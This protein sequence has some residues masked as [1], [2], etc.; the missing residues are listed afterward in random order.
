MGNCTWSCFRLWHTRQNWLQIPPPLPKPYSS[1]TAIFACL[2]PIIGIIA[3]ITYVIISSRNEDDLHWI[4]I[5]DGKPYWRVSDGYYERQYEQLYF[6]IPER[7]WKNNP[8]FNNPNLTL[9][10]YYE[11]DDDERTWDCTDYLD[12]VGNDLHT[13]L[14]QSDNYTISAMLCYYDRNREDEGILLCREDNTETIDI[15]IRHLLY[16]EGHQNYNGLRE[17]LIMPW[18]GNTSIT[19]TLQLWVNFDWNSGSMRGLQAIWDYNEV[20]IKV[21][22]ICQYLSFFL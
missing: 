6:D 22:C 14:I 18:D 12:P 7:V 8:S 11:P 4:V 17:V 2:I 3:F 13:N 21:Y 15:G 5:K 10:Q 9:H 19:I 1:P 16:P 20:E